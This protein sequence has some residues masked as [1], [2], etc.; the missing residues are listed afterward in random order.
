MKNK[1]NNL[2]PYWV[3]GFTDGESSFSVAIY[4]NNSYKAGYKFVPA[5]AI[6]LKCKDLDLLYKKSFFNGAGKKFT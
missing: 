2:K 5:F 4:R 6:E 3:R 1:Y